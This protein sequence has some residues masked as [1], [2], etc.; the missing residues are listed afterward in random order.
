[1]KKYHL[2]IMICRTHKFYALSLDDANGCGTRI[3]GGKCCGRWET[4]KDFSPMSAT[5]LR[6]LISSLER[7]LEETE[8]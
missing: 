6:E 1:M 4:L 2:S 7:A 5:D 3:A 8:Q